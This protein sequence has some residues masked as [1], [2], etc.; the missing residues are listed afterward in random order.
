MFRTCLDCCVCIHCVAGQTLGEGTF[1]K[2][3]FGTHVVTGEK[4]A[5]KILEKSRIKE[6]RGL[7]AGRACDGVCLDWA[8]R[9]TAD[10]VVAVRS[11][12]GR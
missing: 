10:A 6:V 7:G 2:V 1:G 12:A 9:S 11:P 3:K 4:V 8:V 5:I